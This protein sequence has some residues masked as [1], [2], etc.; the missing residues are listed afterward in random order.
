[1]QWIVDTE[2]RLDAFLAAQEHIA[3]R[4]K[5]KSYIQDGLVSVNDVVVTKPAYV[6]HE[7]DAVS[8]DVEKI[9]EGI[10]DDGHIEPMDLGLEV[11]YEDDACLVVNKPAGYAVHPGDGMQPGEATVLHGV[12]HVFQDRRLPFSAGS[13]LVHRLD[14]DTTGC[15]LVA[16]TPEAHVALQKQFADRTV[17]K[18]YLALVAGVPDPAEA[19]IDAPIG[20][21]LTDRT[22]MSVL[23]TS[24]SREAKT[25]YRTLDASEDVALLSCDLHTGRTHQIRVHLR[26]IGHPILGDPTYESS[27]SRKLSE[28]LGIR[29]ICLH[30]RK[31]VFTSGA[32]GTTVEVIAPESSQLQAALDATGLVD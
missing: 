17:S 32:T 7:G 28:T 27:V 11:L 16:K 29:R 23:Q 21:N 26:S 19:V 2:E 10:D 4:S 5:A 9:D 13:V 1:M 6:L 12:A 8:I 14:K 3:S 30:S 15:L 22:K 31:L 24:V 18:Q 20:R 25:I